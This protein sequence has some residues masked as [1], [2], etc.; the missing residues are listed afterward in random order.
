MSNHE[1]IGE[2][3]N[4][5]TVNG[6][7]KDFDNLIEQLNNG[8]PGAFEEIYKRCS[9]SIAFLCQK[10]CDTKEDAEEVVQDTFVIAYKKAAELRGDT[11]LAYLRKIAVRE[12]FRKRD[13]NTY[14]YEYLV[15]SDK[16]TEDH[17]ELD[18]SLLPEEALQN[19]ERQDELF[20]IINEL[21]KNRR[22]MIYLYYYADINTEEIAR[23]YDCT[24][25]T[26]YNTL[27]AARSTI[28]SKLDGEDRK[29]TK[30]TAFAP[31]GALFLVEEQVF[32]ASYVSA[33]APSIV[34]A[35]V[36]GAAKSTTGYIIATC[37]AVCVASVAAFVALQPAEPDY[38]Y[39]PTY[40]IYAPVTEEV[41]EEDIIEEIQRPEPG[42]ERPAQAERP[43]E[44]PE[45]AD[46]P[47][48]AEVPEPPVDAEPDEP[49]TEPI[50]EPIDRTPEI[51][52][53]LA[54]ATTYG[55]INNI[56]ARYGFVRVTQVRS[57]T[58]Q[59][60]YN[61]YALNEGSGEILVGVGIYEDSRPTHIR[62]EH[63]YNRQRPTLVI[64]L[65]D[66]M[67]R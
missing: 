16:P 41:A 67:Y 47:E 19:K 1:K 48:Q 66:W 36:A 42:E 35:V 55:D 45:P 59:E 54:G 56:I 37:V 49:E 27:S 12:C 53:A 9:S 50:P 40:E 65:M 25:S 28:K 52:A 58:E 20:R 51:L 64:G 46:E 4:M 26:V 2:R 32:A 15:Y 18:E 62:F 6:D 23:L 3:I 39:E 22:E 61:F 14:R 31:L 7:Y 33:A 11:L 38:V 34:G 8:D 5:S 13:K 63:F 17:P 60:L 29:A 57:T 30:V 44:M 43:E 24:N 21:P 10:F